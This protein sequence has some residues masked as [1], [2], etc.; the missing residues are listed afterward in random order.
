ME[1]EE[2]VTNSH[3]IRFA[4]DRLILTHH[5]KITKKEIELTEA[6]ARVKV[7]V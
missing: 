5:G 6:K 3:I 7:G 2:G 4:I 1:K